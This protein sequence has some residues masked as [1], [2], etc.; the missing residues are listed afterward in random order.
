MYLNYLFWRLSTHQT[1]SFW[2]SHHG[3]IWEIGRP[4]NASFRASGN[5]SP[6]HQFP[7]RTAFCG[8][9]CKEQ[10]NS[11]LVSRDCY[12]TVKVTLKRLKMNKTKR[13][14]LSC[15][16]EPSLSLFLKLPEWLG[17]NRVRRKAYIWRGSSG[18]NHKGNCRDSSCPGLWDVAESLMS[19]KNQYL[20][21][22]L[23]YTFV[24][25]VAWKNCCVRPRVPIKIRQV[26]AC[27]SLRLFPGSHEA[28]SSASQETTVHCHWVPST[29]DGAGSARIR[30]THECAHHLACMA[31]RAGRV[32]ASC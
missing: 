1:L 25:S 15:S 24:S 6:S 22:V 14:I 12:F 3:T 23:F 19:S 17:T 16:V 18:E 20:S 28:L 7:K 9:V 8:I 30:H 2:W 4:G 5:P 10:N 32:W 31:R 21:P 27:F 11:G 26:S 13:V 29:I